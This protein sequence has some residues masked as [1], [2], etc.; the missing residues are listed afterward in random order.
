MKRS[1]HCPWKSRLVAC[2]NCRGPRLSRSQLAAVY[3]DA[4]AGNLVSTRGN[5]LI[6][7]ATQC[8]DASDTIAIVRLN[9][10]SVG[11]IS[12]SLRDRSS[13]TNANRFYRYTC[14]IG[15]LRNARDC[16]G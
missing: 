4:R 2:G 11:T 14:R 9:G 6:G 5:K 1:K 12:R 8:A 15:R 16:G 13:P 7:A 3:F 10:V